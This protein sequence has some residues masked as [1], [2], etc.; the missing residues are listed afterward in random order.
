ME[1]E[2]IEKLGFTKEVSWETEDQEKKELWSQIGA[3]KE[4]A[5]KN[6]QAQAAY[7]KKKHTDPVPEVYSLRV[8]VIFL[9]LRTKNHKNCILIVI[10]KNDV[11]FFKRTKI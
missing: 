9:R 3:L 11:M 10:I 5:R 4:R 1:K 7:E 8:F 6:A 2:E